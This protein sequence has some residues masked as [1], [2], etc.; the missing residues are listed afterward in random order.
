MSTSLRLINEKGVPVK[1]YLAYMVAIS[2]MVLTAEANADSQLL[3]NPANKH[4][5]QRFD[6]GVNWAVAKEACLAKGGYLATI[7]SQ[8]EN[9]WAWNNFGKSPANYESRVGFWIGGTDEASEGTWVWSNGESW[10]YTNW[11]QNQPDNGSGVVQ[12]YL[13]MWI[14][15]AWDDG[16]RPDRTAGNSYL[17]EWDAVKPE[18]KLS[19][20]IPVGHGCQAEALNSGNTLT[21]S[22]CENTLSGTRVQVYS[23]GAQSKITLLLKPTGSTGGYFFKSTF[24]SA[25]KVTSVALQNV[26][27]LTRLKQSSIAALFANLDATTSNRVLGSYGTPV[28]LLKGDAQGDTTSVLATLPKSALLFRQLYPY[29]TVEYHFERSSATKS[30]QVVIT[31]GLSYDKLASLLQKSGLSFYFG[32]DLDNEVLV[33]RLAPTTAQ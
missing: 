28:D 13:A 19:W 33:E 14:D 30:P 26:R 23:D 1:N 31:S 8:A 20:T 16:F 17:C 10:S 4:L 6:A 32:G 3:S 21:A 22:A 5:Y 11:S 29:Q 15:G 27:P 25:L 24:P 7:T 12:N 9:D 18:L 2:A